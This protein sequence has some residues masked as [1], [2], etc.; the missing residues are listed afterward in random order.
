MGTFWLVVLTDGEDTHSSSSYNDVKDVF[1]RLSGLPDGVLNIALIGVS[2]AAGPRTQ[3]QTLAH[4]GGST[5]KFVDA[6]NLEQVTR[7]FDEIAVRL[8]LL[9][10]SI[11]GDGAAAGVSPRVAVAGVNPRVPREERNGRGAI[12]CVVIVVV[13]IVLVIGKLW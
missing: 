1:R 12:C 11:G 2:L 13:V 3:L 8:H 6:Q 7:A 10:V 9:R 4:L 5:T